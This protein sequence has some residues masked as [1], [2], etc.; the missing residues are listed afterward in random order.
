MLVTFAALTCTE[1]LACVHLAVQE[2]DKV[3]QPSVRHLKV[4]VR[5]CQSQY[6][7]F[8]CN[9]LNSMVDNRGVVEHCGLPRF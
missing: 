4:E 5:Q 1:A 6:S 9:C 2:V 3:Q 8:T 7:C